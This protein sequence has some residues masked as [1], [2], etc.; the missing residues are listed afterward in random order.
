[1]L[2]ELTHKNHFVYLVGLHIHYKMIRGPYNIKLIF[3]GFE[4]FIDY[5]DMTLFSV[6]YG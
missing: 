6:V 3:G 1:M 2:N 5:T 4:F